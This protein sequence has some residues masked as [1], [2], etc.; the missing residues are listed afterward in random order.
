MRIQ[1]YLNMMAAMLLT[2]VTIVPAMAQ[3]RAV[4]DRKTPILA[5]LRATA[6][7]ATAVIHVWA[8]LTLTAR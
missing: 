1:H 6:P 2:I 4:R 5:E 3:S 7:C 8:R